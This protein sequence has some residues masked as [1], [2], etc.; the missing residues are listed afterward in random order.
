MGAGSATLSGASS[1][2]APDAAAA[3]PSSPAPAAAPAQEPSLDVVLNFLGMPLDVVLAFLTMREVV[4]SARVARTWALAACAHAEEVAPAFFVSGT[5]VSCSDHKLEVVN[6]SRGKTKKKQKG[7]KGKRGE[8]GEKG[9]EGEE[10]EKGEKGE[11]GDKTEGKEEKKDADDHC[12]AL[13]GRWLLPHETAQ[14]YIEEQSG[15]AIRERSGKAPRHIRR[16]LVAQ[17]RPTYGV[18]VEYEVGPQ[19][20]TE[21]KQQKKKGK[22]GEDRWPWKKVGSAEANPDPPA[23][24]AREL[25]WSL[26]FVHRRARISPID[27]LNCS[28]SPFN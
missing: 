10:G 18:A 25:P 1:A 7:K 15:V 20:A 19:M 27:L 23:P 13:I 22:N 9:E 28:L 26:V 2:P 21:K 8:E 11:E 4:R 12:V 3:A 17:K 6:V 5:G 16:R 14:V 24:P